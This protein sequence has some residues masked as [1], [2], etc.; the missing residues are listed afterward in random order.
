MHKLRW[1]ARSR[2]GQNGGLQGKGTGVEPLALRRPQKIRPPLQPRY[3]PRFSGNLAVDGVGK[4]PHLPFKPLTIKR[5]PMRA[6]GKRCSSGGQTLAAARAPC[7]NHLAAADSRHT[8]PKTVPALANE[9]AR[10][11]STF[12][13]NAPCRKSR[14]APG[15][16][17]RGLFC[18]EPEPAAQGQAEICRLETGCLMRQDRPQVN[19][20]LRGEA[21]GGFAP[22]WLNFK[23]N[24]RLGPISQGCSKGAAEAMKGLF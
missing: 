12:H 5:K 11:V 20:G 7:R 2:F 18:F 16:M 13:L 6:N 21:A 24:Q 9:L 17:R 8:S 19:E 10:L 14:P 1:L 4:L 3:R 22:F 15:R 23:S